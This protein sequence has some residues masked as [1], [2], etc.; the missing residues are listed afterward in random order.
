MP[1]GFTDFLTR[2]LAWVRNRRRWLTLLAALWFSPLAFPQA[3]AP[4]TPQVL[5]P[6]EFRAAFL[7]KIPR[8]V[9]WP[10]SAFGPGDTELVIAL[11]EGESFAGLLEALLKDVRVADRPVVVR[12]IASL[13]DLPHCQI[14]FVPAARSDLLST[15]PANRRNG[16]L[17]VGEDP[18]FTRLG[19]VCNLSLADRKL[20]VNVRNARAAGLE[21]QSRLLR[22]AEVER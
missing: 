6:N 17:T 16:L 11:I 20:T 4:S 5:G 3:N 12:I 19:G 13:E 2:P 7:S 15:L 9:T 22:I 8:F 14:L 1:A 21:L 18:R 10:E